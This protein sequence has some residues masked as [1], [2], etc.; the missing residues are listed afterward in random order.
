MSGVMPYPWDKGDW[1][2][3]IKYGRRMTRDL[4]RKARLSSSL[5]HFGVKNVRDGYNLKWYTL[6]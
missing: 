5:E 1:G 2:K 3:Q 6:C 4:V